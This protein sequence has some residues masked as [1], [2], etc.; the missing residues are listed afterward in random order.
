VTGTDLYCLVTEA[1]GRKQLGTCPRLV[2][3]IG[4]TGSRTR[5]LFSR[6]SNQATRQRSNYGDEDEDDNKQSQCNLERAALPPLTAENNLQQSPHR[7]QWDA[8][9][10]PRKLPLFLRR[11]PPHLIH[12][13]LDDPTHHSKQYPDPISHF[14]TVRPP[15]RQTDRPTDR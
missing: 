4:T 11:S 10:L 5:D 3:D 15:D 6:K 12:P 13:S 14:V 2:P 8:P 7:L 9:H 1:Q